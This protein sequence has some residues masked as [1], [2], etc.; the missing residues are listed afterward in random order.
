MPEQWKIEI[1]NSGNGRITFLP[2]V[3]GAGAGDPLHAAIGD[4]ISWTNRTD[5]DISLEAVNPPNVPNFNRTVP[6]GQPSDFFQLDRDGIEYRSIN[7]PQSHS[8]TSA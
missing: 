8:I 6:A 3:Q 7:P 1:L 2:D 5:K 4:L